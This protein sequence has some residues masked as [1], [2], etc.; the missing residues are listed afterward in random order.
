VHLSTDA[1]VREAPHPY[2]ISLNFQ[3]NFDEDLASVVGKWHGRRHVLNID[4]ISPGRIHAAFAVADVAAA[5]SASAVAD[6]AKAAAYVLN[7][8]RCCCDGFTRG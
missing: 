3:E 2:H 7:R 5:D 4:Y 1:G 8:H 6:A